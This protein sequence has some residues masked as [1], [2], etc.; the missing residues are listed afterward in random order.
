MNSLKMSYAQ[1][2]EFCTHPISKRLFQIMEEKKTNLA[3]SADV[4]SP[5][6]LLR[7]CRSFRAPYLRLKNSYRYFGSFRSYNNNETE[8]AGPAT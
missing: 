6:D 2:A 7:F 8:R 5:D 3:L 1:R 4:I